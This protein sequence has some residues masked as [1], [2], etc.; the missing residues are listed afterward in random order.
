MAASIR[1]V[2]SSDTG[3]HPARPSSTNR[4]ASAPRA[5]TTSISSTPIGRTSPAFGSMSVPRSTVSGMVS[6]EV[7]PDRCEACGSLFRPHRA[8]VGWDNLHDPPC[9]S[10]ECRACGHVMHV[11]APRYEDR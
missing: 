1:A 5:R 4:R 10:Y 8:L 6:V 7:G 3:A 9:R 11:E 2:S